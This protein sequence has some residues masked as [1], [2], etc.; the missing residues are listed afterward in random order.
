MRLRLASVVGV[1]AVLL[2]LATLTQRGLAAAFGFEFSFVTAIGVLAVIQGLR[3]VQERRAVE[4][5]RGDTGDPE[6]RYEA[7]VP[8][9]DVD[10]ELAD[11]DGWSRYSVNRRDRLRE[12][13]G[14]AT[15]ETLVATEGLSRE[16]ARDRI[17]AGEWTDDPVAAWFLGEEE[18]LPV[19]EHARRL[20]RG[21]SSFRLGVRRT[22][23]AL[24]R[25]REGGG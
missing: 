14:E 23:D 25:K 18:S 12:R 15:V 7:P 6:L 9:G 11:A 8:G 19:R 21:E 16:A 13:V 5:V 22:V 10:G 17:L 2:G 3:L 24:V 4:P 20:V 1:L